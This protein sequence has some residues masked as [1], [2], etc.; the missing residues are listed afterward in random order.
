MISGI[1]IR[2]TKA[3]STM[4][5]ATVEDMTGGIEL[6]IFPKTYLEYSGLL[7]ENSVFIVDARLSVEEGE[8]PSLMCMRIAPVN[9]ESAAR[10]VKDASRRKSGKHGL[11]LRIESEDKKEEIR[12]ARSALGRVRAGVGAKAVPVYFYFSDTQ[13]YM[14]SGEFSEVIPNEALISELKR[15]LGENNVV[16]K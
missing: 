16:L 11:F 1:K 4:A 2:V 3:G 8:K 12:L 14:V 7:S 15:I 5:N 9:K 13:K 10:A 6:I